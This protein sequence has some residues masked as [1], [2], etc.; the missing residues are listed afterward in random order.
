MRA[1][2]Q[3]FGEREALLALGCIVSGLVFSILSP[4]FATPDNLLTIARNSTELLLIGLGMTLLLGIG[5]ID[6][7]VGSVL[8]LAAIAI[9]RLLEAGAPPV[10]AALAG[11]LDRSVGCANFWR[12]RFCARHRVCLR[13]RLCGR[14]AH[15]VRGAPSC[16][17]QF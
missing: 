14:S 16:H 10:L 11:G 7:S 3:R 9:G 6:V 2:L 17:R 4:Y 5:G 13:R 12:S 1:F 15:A 8:G